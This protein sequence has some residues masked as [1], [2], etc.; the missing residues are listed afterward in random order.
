V[1]NRAQRK[2]NMEIIGPK[3][4]KKKKKEGAGGYENI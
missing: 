2:K 1:K 4:K 3:E